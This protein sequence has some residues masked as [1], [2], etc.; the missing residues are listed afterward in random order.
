MAEYTKINIDIFVPNN[1]CTGCEFCDYS[2]PNRIAVYKCKIF[3]R[4]LDNKK[5]CVECI[6]KR[7]NSKRK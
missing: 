3:R 2:D 4:T 1:N 7:E 6:E 5:P